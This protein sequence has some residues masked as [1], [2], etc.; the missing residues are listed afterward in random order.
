MISRKRINLFPIIF[1][2]KQYGL[3]WYRLGHCCNMDHYSWKTLLL[4]QF[5]FFD[6][7]YWTCPQ[8]GKQHKIKLSYHVEESWDKDLRERNK[9]LRQWE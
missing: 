2:F 3:T 5:A 6:E 7:V 4:L 1:Q 9:L 8:C